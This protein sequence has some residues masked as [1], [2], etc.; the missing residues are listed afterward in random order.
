MM[1]T[2]IYFL[3]WSLDIPS[4]I[5]GNCRNNDFLVGMSALSP[6][7]SCPAPEL[8]PLR[9]LPGVSALAS[10]YSPL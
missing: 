9:A 10:P 6:L 8:F 1:L 7:K 5:L 2:K 3:F 4:K